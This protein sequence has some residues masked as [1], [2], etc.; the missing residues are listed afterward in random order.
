MFREDLKNE[1]FDQLYSETCTTSAFE[2]FNS[3]LSRNIDEHAPFIKKRVK[4]RLCPWLTKDLKKELNLRDKLLRKARL[5]KSDCDWSTYKCQRNRVNNLVRK[6]KANY[7][8]ELPRENADSTE[9]FWSALQKAH[10]TKSK[11]TSIAPAI[12]I[13]GQKTTDC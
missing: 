1:E 6:N 13:N 5:S 2:K 11:S 12:N 9:K 7:N 8:K 10:P 4:G 3:I